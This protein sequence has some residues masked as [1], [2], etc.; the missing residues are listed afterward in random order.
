MSVTRVSTILT[1]DERERSAVGIGEKL[2]IGLVPDPLPVGSQ[3][4]TLTITFGQ[5]L[6]EVSFQSYAD[7]D[8]AVQHLVAE[9]DFAARTA[10][11]AAA[12]ELDR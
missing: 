11:H 7:L 5:L 12:R 10:N 8:D 4:P 1:H 3:L 2:L 6:L 9:L